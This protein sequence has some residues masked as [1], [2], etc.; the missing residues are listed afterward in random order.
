RRQIRSPQ[1]KNDCAVEVDARIM[2]SDARRLPDHPVEVVGVSTVRE[3]L[4]C[5]HTR[6][7]LRGVLI[8]RRESS[9]EGQELK[10]RSATPLWRKEPPGR[11]GKTKIARVISYLASFTQRK[12]ML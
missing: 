5:L 12:P 7:S 11:R 6:L 8:D 1:R 2:N 4:G 3:K 9:G 10:F